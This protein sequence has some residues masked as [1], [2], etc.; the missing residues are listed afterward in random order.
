MPRLEESEIKKYW[1]I[2]QGLKPVD[3]KLTGDKV[4]PVLKNSVY[5]NLNYLQFGN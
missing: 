1:Q 4:S 2:F 3:N 5:Q